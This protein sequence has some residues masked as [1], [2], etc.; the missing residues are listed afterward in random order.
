MM[1][2]RE[3]AMR[4]SLRFAAMNALLVAT[5]AAIWFGGVWPALAFVLTILL[6]TVGDEAAGDELAIFDASAVTFY[7]VMLRA[8]LPLLALVAGLGI[9][10]VT[11]VL[12]P[13]GWGEI[14]PTLL[15]MGLM[16]GAAGTNVAHELIHRPE[17]SRDWLIG[18]WLLAFT[19]DTSF[20]IEHVHGHHRHVGTRQDPATA[21]RGETLHAFLIRSTCGQIASAWRFEMA[22]LARAGM[23]GWSRHNRVLRGQVMTLVLVGLAG[24]IGGLAGIAAF[25]LMAVQG[26]AYLE[27]VNYIEH[28]GL[29]REP[30]RRVAP[31][32]A[33]NSHRAVSGALLY[34]LPRH[35]GHH[36]A[37][38]RPFWALEADPGAP[39]LPYGYKT[40]ILLALVPP[41][42]RRAVDPRLADWDARLAT[43]AERA[44]ARA[45]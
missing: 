2:R 8:T 24:L 13:A 5:A 10:R 6:V 31:H 1:G 3:N 9:A 12:G 34:N 26:K 15:A 32:H 38:T 21:R 41:L 28:Y 37:A 40:M 33:W 39:L 43:E 11:G 16:A 42:F 45:A 23:R 20:A 4:P 30:C 19:G 35:A 7:T 27:A 44:L 18:R 36:M 29:T 14:V 17:T 22:R 25:A